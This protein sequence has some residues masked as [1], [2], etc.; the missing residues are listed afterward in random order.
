MALACRY[1]SA[2]PAAHLQL[3]TAELWSCDVVLGRTYVVLAWGILHLHP[4]H[5]VHWVH[6]PQLFQA[7][8]MGRRC[9]RSSAG[10]ATVVA[11]AAFMTD[12]MAWMI[13][14]Q[15]MASASA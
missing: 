11:H 1:H 15:A 8:C 12:L 4:P 2:G 13:A 14:M 5:L 10:A 3:F 7:W 6:L 9:C